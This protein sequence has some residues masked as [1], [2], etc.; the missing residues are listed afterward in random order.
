MIHG[1]LLTIG[2][3]LAAPLSL[4]VVETPVDHDALANIREC[5]A[6]QLTRH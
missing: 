2:A 6:G 4:L 5:L 1:V 3:L